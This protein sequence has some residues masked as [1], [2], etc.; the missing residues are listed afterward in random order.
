MISAPAVPVQPTKTISIAAL[1]SREEHAAETSS[2]FIRPS[3]PH[4][5]LPLVQPGGGPCGHHGDVSGIWHSPPYSGITYVSCLE[6][7]V[8][9]IIP[10]AS[11][12]TAMSGSG[13][14]FRFV[15]NS[16]YTVPPML[17]HHPLAHL[18]APYT[19]PSCIDDTAE[20][21]HAAF[22]AHD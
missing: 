11:I 7:L 1:D 3:S 8:D 4:P 2:S 21:M 14:S 19:Q 13:L 18:Y 10:A 17:Q 5:A 16:A 20:K 6:S 22:G 15:E 9:T 12:R